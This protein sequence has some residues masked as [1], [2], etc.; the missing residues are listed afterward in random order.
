MPGIEAGKLYSLGE[1]ALILRISEKTLHRRI[2][3]KKIEYF[4]D[5]TYRFRGQAIIE[6]INTYT[7]KPDPEGGDEQ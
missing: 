4:F 3:D 1:T 2:I 7:T 6:Y 5:G